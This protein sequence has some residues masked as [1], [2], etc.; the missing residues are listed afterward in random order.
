LRL[1]ALVNGFI[2]GFGVHKK[3]IVAGGS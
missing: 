2:G 3:M 1:D